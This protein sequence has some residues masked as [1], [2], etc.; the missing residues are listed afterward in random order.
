MEQYQRQSKPK[1]VKREYKHP[2]IFKM[3]WSFIK[4]VYKHTS[5]GMNIVPKKEYAKRIS[6]CYVCE[7]RKAERCT[8]CGCSIK[9][10]S[11]WQTSSCPKKKW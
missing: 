9:I 4:A 5:T 1:I 7:F 11:K 8:I 10:K 2:G 6:T 3:L